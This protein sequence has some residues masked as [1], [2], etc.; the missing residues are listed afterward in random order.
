M[1][2]FVKGFT[3]D[4]LGQLLAVGQLQGVEIDGFKVGVI[5]LLKFH[6]VTTSSQS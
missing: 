1:D 4:L 2:G 5:D 3:G 6:C